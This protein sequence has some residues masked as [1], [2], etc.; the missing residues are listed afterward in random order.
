[1]KVLLISQLTERSKRKLTDFNSTGQRNK[2]GRLILYEVTPSG[3][4]ATITVVIYGN[5]TIIIIGG[6]PAKR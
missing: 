4:M 3:P 5:A 6:V 1:M 2:M